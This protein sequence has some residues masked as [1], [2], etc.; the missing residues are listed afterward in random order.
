[1]EEVGVQPD[2]VSHNIVINAFGKA[3]RPQEAAQWLAQMEQ[4][5]LQPDQ[6]SYSSVIGAFGRAGMPGEAARWLER[7]IQAG[8]RP[9]IVC[10]NSVI[11][12]YGKAKMPEAAGQTMSRMEAA[13]ITPTTKSFNI[14]L[15]AMARSSNDLLNQAE[16]IASVMLHRGMRLDSYSFGALVRCCAYPLRADHAE[17]WFRRFLEDLPFNERVAYNFQRAVGVERASAVCAEY[18][19]RFP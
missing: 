1:M 6:V 11:H 5:F 2:E 9:N 13:G 12:A 4:V 14:L 7:M 15:D 19:I 3:N 8:L 18:G 16:H 17:M 10:W